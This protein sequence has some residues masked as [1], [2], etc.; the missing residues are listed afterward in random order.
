[1]EQAIHSGRAGWSQ[2]ENDLLWREIKEASQEGAPLRGVFEKMGKTL[3]RKPNSVRNYYYMQ[4]RAKDTGA[5][6]RAAPFETFTPEEIHDLLYA[7]LSAR[8]RGQSVR[9][10]VMELS[11]GDRA[12]MLRYQNKYRS[13]LRKKP[14]MIES[15]MEELKRDGLPCPPA[16][17]LSR[18]NEGKL[19]SPALSIPDDPDVQLILQGLSALI[20]RCQG[21]ELSARDR[22]KVRQDL[23]LMQLEEIQLAARDMV[24][25]CKD[26]LGESE[27]TRRDHMNAF[28][29]SLCEKLS[30]LESAAG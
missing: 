10:S 15:V 28:C 17:S 29:D 25:L 23:L 9:A 16:S 20:Q 14:Y 27:E 22:M 3:G 2:E 26:F 13:I 1:M 19:S 5:Y 18:A 6:R 30:R 8:G 4:L 7:V 12:L 24:S 11:K 21:N